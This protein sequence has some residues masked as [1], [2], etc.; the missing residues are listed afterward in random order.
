MGGG[1][2]VGGDCQ[3]VTLEWIKGWVEDLVEG[4]P[5]REQQQ[6]QGSG[7]RAKGER[8]GRAKRR[9][10]LSHQTGYPDAMTTFL[11]SLI[12]PF[13]FQGRMTE[14][15]LCLAR[16][17]RQPQV[18]CQQSRRIGGQWNSLLSRGG[19]SEPGQGARRVSAYREYWQVD[20][21]YAGEVSKARLR[22]SSHS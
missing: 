1:G 21:L 14:A 12:S 20:G 11:P 6:H 16:R 15:P 5:E 8:D 13:T 9:R 22:A 2:N 18:N 3:K 7:G 19:M 4:G 10:E 17:E